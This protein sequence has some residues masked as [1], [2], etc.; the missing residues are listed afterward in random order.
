VAHKLWLQNRK[1]VALSLR[2]R[3][4]DVFAVD[5]LPG[6]SIGKGELLRHATVVVTG[7]AHHVSLGGTGKCCCDRH[8][9]I[10][11]GVL[12]GAAATILGNVR[13]GEVPPGTPWRTAVGNLARLIGGNRA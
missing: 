3:I 4:A 10:G 9:K 7:E 2:S 13:I 12:F 11:D 5:I 8:P 6:A 1:P